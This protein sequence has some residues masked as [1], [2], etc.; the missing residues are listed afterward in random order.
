MAGIASVFCR[1][2]PWIFVF[3]IVG[4]GGFERGIMV[5]IFRIHVKRR[6]GFSICCSDKELRGFLGG[7]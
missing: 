5:A 6:S 2:S 1:F 4:R 7:W 3:M